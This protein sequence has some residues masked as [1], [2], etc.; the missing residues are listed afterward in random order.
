MAAGRW[1]RET[2]RSE[3]AQPADTF[4]ASR[5]AFAELAFADGT[6]AVA[7]DRHDRLPCLVGVGRVRVK[8]APWPGPPEWALMWPW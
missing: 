5:A 2:P 8:R 1:E 4:A 6:Q 3:A 7:L